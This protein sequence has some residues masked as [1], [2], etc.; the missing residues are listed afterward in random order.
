MSQLTLQ[1]IITAHTDA[2]AAHSEEFLPT[3]RRPSEISLLGKQ[4]R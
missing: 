3:I 2:L 1:E 4:F